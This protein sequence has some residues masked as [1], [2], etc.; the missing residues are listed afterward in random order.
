MGRLAVIKFSLTGQPLASLGSTI[1]GFLAWTSA[2]LLFS[3]AGLVLVSSAAWHPLIHK[4]SSS[5]ASLL[6][7]L[8]KHLVTTKPAWTGML[9]ALTGS[10]A[11]PVPLVSLSAPFALSLHRFRQLRST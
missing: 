7:I 9:S 4:S 2:R 6:S 5:C 11:F 10:S 1:H 3:K 8:I